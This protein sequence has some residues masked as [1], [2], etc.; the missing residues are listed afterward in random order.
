MK[1]IRFKNKKFVPASHEDPKDPGVWKKILLGK[2][3]LIKGEIQMVNWAKLPKGR[4]FAPHYHEDMDEVFIMIK[5]SVQM[6]VDQEVSSVGEGDV[7]VV[8][9]REVHEMKNESRQ[10]IEYIVFGIS[11]GS[12]GK[13]VNV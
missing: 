8:Q 12:D 10:D 5:G 11:R 6:K 2:G 1:L 3:D 9:M 7:V 13:S 4:S